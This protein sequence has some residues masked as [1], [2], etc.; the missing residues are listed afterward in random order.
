M[1]ATRYHYS[2]SRFIGEYTLRAKMGQRFNA[3][4]IHNSIIALREDEEEIKMNR[5]LIDKG[6]LPRRVTRGISVKR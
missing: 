5:A 6:K 2:P 1:V 4:Y 3:E